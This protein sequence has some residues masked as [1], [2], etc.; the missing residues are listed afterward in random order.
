MHFEK[1]H[2]DDIV[3]CYCAGH[4]TID[5]RFYALF[6]SENPES[7]AYAYYGDRFENRETLWLDRGGCMSIIPFE[8][9]K[10]EFLAVNEFYLKVSPSRAKIVHGKKTENGW[11]IKDLFSLPFLHRFDIYHV[12]G[13]DLIICAVIARDKDNK[14]DWSRPGQIYAAALPE[15]L[16]EPIE[17]RLLV[18]GCYRNHGY[19][20][21]CHD[22]KVCGYFGSDQGV[23]RITPPYEEGEDWQ[24][25]KVLDGMV[26]E[27]ATIDLDGDGLDE[28]MTIEPFHGDQIKIYHLDENG[29]YREVWAYGREIDFAHTLVGRMLA[30]RPAFVAGVRRKD[31]E[32][33]AVTYED[34]EYRV[35]DVDRGGGPANVDVVNCGGRDLIL[36]ANHT[37]NEAAVYIVSE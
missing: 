21:G 34:G 31:C 16:D 27:I 33:F 13:R 7:Q 35:T 36:A 23:L 6:A 3:R 20:R 24:I 10:G 30:G 14:E 15:D 17:L 29:K 9:R 25:E 11:E 1:I 28:M 4:I 19:W 26:G 2:L 18:D 5:D 12:N 32:L 37:R 8:T 22:G